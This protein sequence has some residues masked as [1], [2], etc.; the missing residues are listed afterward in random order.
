[1]AEIMANRSESTS[2]DSSTFDS[3]D[4]EIINIENK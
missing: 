3:D 2:D 1:M 4:A